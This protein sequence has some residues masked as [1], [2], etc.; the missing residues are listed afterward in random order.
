M[1]MNTVTVS[2]MR[3]PVTVTTL[4]GQPVAQLVA[5]CLIYDTLNIEKCFL[6]VYKQQ[7]HQEPL[8]LAV[9]EVLVAKTRECSADRAQ[10]QA[11]MAYI[12]VYTAFQRSAALD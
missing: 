12:N 11:C 5:A 2:A 3:S 1:A 8:F 7:L 6:I 9:V 10:T 4:L